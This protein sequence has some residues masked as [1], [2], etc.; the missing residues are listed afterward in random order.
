MWQKEL[1]SIVTIAEVVNAETSFADST[2]VVEYLLT[3]SR[4]VAFPAT[5]LFFALSSLRRDG[6]DFIDELYNQGVRNFVVNKQKDFAQYSG[7]NFLQVENTLLA[8][9]RL[10]AWHRSHFTCPVI[11]ITGSNG[12]TIVKEWLYQLLS[13]DYNII[14]SPRS[15]NS[16]IGVP[17]SV[18]Q[19]TA[20]HNLAIFEAGISKP[21]EMKALQ[22]IIQ[23]TI[24]IITN[25]GEA[26]SENFISLAQKANEKIKLFADADIVFY[27]G[28]NFII[29]NEINTLQK[30][31]RFSWGKE[32]SNDLII[33]SINTTAQQTTVSALYKNKNVSIVIPFTDDASIENAVIAWCV[34]LY[35]KIPKKKIEQR[36]SGLQP[37]NMRLQL[38]KAINGCS[39]INDSYS[40][41]INSFNIALDFLLQQHQFSAKTVILS[42]FAIRVEDKYYWQI[43]DVLRAKKISRV[44]TIGDNWYRLQKLLKGAVKSTS[45][46]ITTKS[47]LDHFSANHFRNEAILL[48]GARRFA[49]ETIVSELEEKV[50]RTVLEINLT[51]LT[52]NLKQY[53]QQLQPGTKLMAMIKAGGYG[54]GSAEVANVL[55][56]HKV[57]Y[58]AVAYADEGTELRKAGISLPVLVLNVDE[59]AFEVLVDFNLEP[60]LFSFNII[61][62]FNNYLFQQGIQQY[63]VHIK[64]DTGMHR[65]GFEESDMPDL[66]SFLQST[67]RLAVK[68]VLSHLAASE[69]HEEDPFTLHQYEIFDRCCCA[70]QNALGYHFI[71]HIANSAAIFRHPQI[72]LDMVRLGIGMYGIDSANDHQLELQTVCTLKTTIAQLRSVK[73]GD[74]VGYNRKGLLHRDSIIATL[75]IGYADGFSR[76]LS[77]GNGAVFINGKNAPVVGSVCMDMTMVDVT[78]IVGI[79]EGDEV[80]V[81]GSHIFVQQVAKQCDTIAYEILTSISQRVKRVYIEE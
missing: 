60:E 78:D 15:Y 77:N 24:G 30:P 44:I 52:H 47:F 13:P 40:F 36:F 32:S 25:L 20:Q 42:D 63:P 26:H 57:D 28:D 22:N 6:H 17:L 64:L 43:A 7:A 61:R 68:S 71:R 45:H 38:M 72:Q 56:F 2:S 27:N 66:I 10:A 37:V 12:K 29:K 11:G 80:E 70:L 48:K 54:S 21:E 16:Q 18:W 14:R 65:L 73:N 23:P 5:S 67:N 46:F 59:A 1:Y 19:M 41:D 75:R 33:S 35:F 31:L 8:L 58:L 76:R 34:C 51:A 74:A 3:D 9:Q 79:K 49:F 53:Q 81:F 55:Q 62:A 39:I 50:H 4:R 69:A